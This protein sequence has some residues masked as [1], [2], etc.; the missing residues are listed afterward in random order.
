MN[1]F[2]DIRS[3]VAHASATWVKQFN[4]QAYE[5]CIS[6]YTDDAWMKSHPFG[7]FRGID[8]IGDFW[9]GFA[10]H[11]PRQ[12]EYRDIRI[13]VIDERTAMLSASWSMNICSGY[14][15]K[16]LWV[17]SDKGQWQLQEDDFSVLVQRETPRA[18][19]EETALVVVDIQND[20]F[21]GGKMPLPDM[22][23][24]TARSVK[25]LSRF[26]EK[27]LP[28]IHVQHIFQTDEAPF[29]TPDGKGKDIHPDVLPLDGEAHHVKSG[30]N[31]FVD[32]T[33][34][35]TLVKLG[36]RKLVFVGAM[37]HMCVEAAATTSSNKGY[38]TVVLADCVTS[39]EVG[40]QGCEVSSEGVHA[41]AMAA[42]DMGYS[43]VCLAEEFLQT[44][45]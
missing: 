19:S 24:I 39:P 33:L 6:T 36:V 29:F 40:Y 23:A 31:A 42:L 28:V 14:I 22:E 13:H 27:Q 3:E 41:A 35:D 5:A 2:E 16:E 15:S 26:R 12:L 21:P 4:E 17:K 7:E 1:T 32:T 18:I 45:P 11:Q 34:E 30:L 37:A 20:Y 44:M 25:V 43:Q 10:K 38:E 8:Q 9:R